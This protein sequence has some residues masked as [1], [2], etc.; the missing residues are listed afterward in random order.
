MINSFRRL[1]LWGKASCIINVFLLIVIIGLCI[2]SNIKQHK[3]EA[4]NYELKNTI[5][6]QTLSI[7]YLEAEVHNQAAKIEEMTKKLEKYQSSSNNSV[8]SGKFKITAYC[9]CS[10]CCGKWAG[11]NTA[12]GTKPTAGRTI[13]V[14]TSVIPFG[15]KVVIDGHTYV[16]EDTGGAIK[17]NRIDIFF[18]SHQKALEWG[19]RYKDVQIIK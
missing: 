5:A 2:S 6:E 16:A 10:T 9:A 19:V 15:T 3:L 4:T 18:D 12:S 7:E 1:P 13:A 8:R 17:G 11:G 14:D